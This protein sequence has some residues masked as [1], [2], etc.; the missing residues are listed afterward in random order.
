MGTQPLLPFFK[1][2]SGGLGLQRLTLLHQRINEISLATLRKLV[3]HKFRHV[4]LLRCD[5]HG[6]DDLATTGRLLIQQRHVQIAIDRHRQSPRNRGGRHD[7][8]VRHDPLADQRRPLRHAEF[9]LLVDHYQSKILEGNRVIEQRVSA[10]DDL[11]LALDFEVIAFVTITRSQRDANS[12][13]L[14]PAPECQIMLLCQNLRGSHQR[15]LA[16]RADGQQHGRHRHEGFPGTHVALQQ[17]VHRPGH[18]HVGEDFPDRTLLRLREIEGKTCVESLEKRSALPQHASSLLAVAGPPPRDVELQDE[19]LLERK[20][21]PGVLG[22]LHGFRKMHV[23][24]SPRP[25]RRIIRFMI[26]GQCRGVDLQQ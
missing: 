15:S 16:T 10:D 20:P 26:R 13:R 7:Q 3:L 9:V 1:R 19:E 22:L 6:G 14:Q 25:H 12:Q 23:T 2:L 4:R 5:P 21:P 8:H 11:R 17:P 24:E 18:P